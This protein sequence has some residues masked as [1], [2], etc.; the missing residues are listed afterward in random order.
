[1]PVPVDDEPDRGVTPPAPVDELHASVL[2]NAEELGY[3]VH[4]V[5]AT[6]LVD[7]VRTIRTERHAPHRSEESRQAARRADADLELQWREVRGTLR[8][9]LAELA[10]VIDVAAD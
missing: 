6:M 2:L 4:G 1:M 8:V 9:G 3:A 7:A 5:A 10:D